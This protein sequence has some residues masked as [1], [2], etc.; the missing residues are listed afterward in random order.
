[1][2]ES[3]SRLQSFLRLQREAAHYERS[4]VEQRRLDKGFS[5]MVK[6]SMGKKRDR[7]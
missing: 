4:E 6:S 7:R 3:G 5:K 2:S 1:M